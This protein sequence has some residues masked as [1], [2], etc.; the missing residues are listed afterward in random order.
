MLYYV[1]D[2]ISY[3]ANIGVDIFRMDAIPYLSKEKGTNAFYI[4]FNRQQLADYLGVERSAMS[5]EISRLASLGLLETRR[6]YFKL[7]KP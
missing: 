5:A 6:S 4:P 7:L 1:L 2:V 3:W